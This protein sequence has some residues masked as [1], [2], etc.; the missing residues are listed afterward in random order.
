MLRAQPMKDLIGHAVALRRWSRLELAVRTRPK[1]NRRFNR[2][3]GRALLH[4][5][6]ITRMVAAVAD[7]TPRISAIETP[8]PIINK[9]MQMTTNPKPP[10]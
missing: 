4:E 2:K 3:L 5:K 6:K 1:R 8:A 7:Y 10:T 9:P